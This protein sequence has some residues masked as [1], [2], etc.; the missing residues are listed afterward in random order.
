MSRSA[1]QAD[2]LAV[3]LRDLMLLGLHLILVGKRMPRASRAGGL[4]FFR[5]SA[6]AGPKTAIRLILFLVSFRGNRS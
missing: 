3:K 4:W 5:F 2:H 1:F 6:T